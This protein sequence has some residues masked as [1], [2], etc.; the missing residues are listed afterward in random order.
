MI[1]AKRDRN[2][3]VKGQDELCDRGD[4]VRVVGDICKYYGLKEYHWRSDVWNYAAADGFKIKIDNS[5]LSVHKAY[6]CLVLPLGSQ[7]IQRVA[8]VNTKV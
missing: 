8:L 4:S 3:G 7:P 6:Y 2:K 5:I 1:T